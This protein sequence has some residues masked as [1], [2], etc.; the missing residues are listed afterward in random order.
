MSDIKV[1]VIGC[2][3]W[4]KNLVRNFHELGALAAVSDPDKE[5]MDEISN[6]YHVD[7]YPIE[8]ILNNNSI[9]GVVI[10][11]PA[12]L[13]S[14]IS[15]MAMNADKHVYV[16]KPLAMNLSQADEMIALSDK[17]K[18]HLMVGHLLQYHPV[19]KKVREI[20]LSGEIGKINYISSIRH[21]LGKIRT[22]EDVIWSFAPHDISMILSLAQNS[23]LSINTESVEIIQPGICDIASISMSFPENI[24]AKVSV[25]W[26]HPT[27]EQKLIIIGDD[28]MIIFDDTLDWSRKLA[29]YNH[30]IEHNKTGPIAVKSEAEYIVVREGEPLKSECQYFLDLIDNQVTPLTDGREGRRVLEVLESASSSKSNN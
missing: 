29:I 1:A 12:S 24:K 18:K 2:G 22:E 13:H 19:F 27:K 16:E 5:T 9:H 21:S 4:G 10:A 28:G 25:S 8:S 14:S 7:G 15:I 6:H 11:A 3:H 17:T 20:V 23:P 30:K 26:M